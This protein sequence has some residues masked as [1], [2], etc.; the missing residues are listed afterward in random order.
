[1]SISEQERIKPKD[2]LGT[3]SAV[4]AILGAFIAA[5]TAGSQAIQGYFQNQIALAKTKQELVLSKR[6]SD[7]TLAETYLKM[8][9]SKETSGPD[10]LMLLGALMEI[11]DHPLQKWAKQ[12][13]KLLTEQFEA[14]SK[15]RSAQIAAITEKDEALREVRKLESEIEEINVL[16][17]ISTGNIEKGDELNKEL[18]VKVQRLAYAKGSLGKI[19]FQIATATSAATGSMPSGTANVD[20]QVNLEASLTVSAVK[21]V[22]PKTPIASIQSNLP[23]ILSAIKEFQI[24]D[25][26]VI[27]AIFGTIRA[28]N[29]GFQPISEF[30]SKFNT[31]EQAFD[32]YEP[33]TP[34]GTRLGNTEPGDGSKFRGRGY[35]QL[36]GRDNYQRTSTRLG[37]ASLLTDEPDL[38]NS[39]EVSARILCAW[40]ADSARVRDLLKAD[41]LRGARGA[42]NGG[43]HNVEGFSEAYNAILAL[44]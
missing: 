7:S 6:Q 29:E 21:A 34:I 40:I 30:R 25:R 15:A 42:I 32:L 44:L 11:E 12:R 9:L 26:K 23:F 27:A 33:G 43:S 39:P 16:L 14:L 36:T 38:A 41:N 19:R 8:I 22:F 17:R 1:M 4:A 5:G 10:K 13:E 20:I 35:I 18:L 31:R 2:L 37:L 3:L 24:F 28:E